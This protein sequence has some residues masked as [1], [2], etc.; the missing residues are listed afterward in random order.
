MADGRIITPF[1][2][3]F[4]RGKAEQLPANIAQ[5]AVDVDLRRGCLEAW[6]TAM[7]V[8]EFGDT[9]PCRVHLSGTCCWTG[10]MNPCAKLVNAA[11]C[12]MTIRSAPCEYPTHA[13]DLCCNPKWCRLGL[14]KPDAPEIEAE[15]TLNV[16]EFTYGRRYVVTFC[17][18][19]HEGPPSP[20]SDSY[21]LNK[22]DPA[23]VTFPAIPKE[24]CITHINLYRLMP[25]GEVSE[26]NFL[27]PEDLINSNAL[28]LNQDTQACYFKV[29]EIPVI[30]CNPAMPFIIDTGS[31]IC[32]DRSL[33]L[34]DDNQPPKEGDCIV[35]ETRA[36]NYVSYNGR[37]VSFSVRHDPHSWPGKARHTMDE[38]VEHVCICE[39]TVFVFT[40][41]TVYTIQDTAKCEDATCRE[42]SRSKCPVPLC[43][44]E[45]CI[46]TES[47]VVFASRNGWIRIAPDGSYDNISKPFFDQRS[48]DMLDPGSICAAKWDGQIVFTSSQGTWL[49]D[50][51]I[52]ASASTEQNLTQL[53]T[54]PVQWVEGKGGELYF[55]DGCDVKEFNAG[56]EWMPYTWKSAP[57]SECDPETFNIFRVLFDDL[58]RQ[59]A[60]GQDVHITF[61]DADGVLDSLKVSEQCDH[62]ICATR[63]EGVCVELSGR[64]TVRTLKYAAG[65]KC[66]DRLS[67]QLG[68]AA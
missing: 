13:T 48:W 7:T 65:K 63:A 14:P 62:R 17:N 23:I 20:P 16:D 67:E 29:A 28:W 10:E 6:R 36:G 2:G 41:S 40:C 21:K 68:A 19:C 66:L 47:G 45:S 12:E 34:T 35:G 56:N 54:Q 51:A 30:N 37:N 39:N 27:H 33:L 60:L 38:D 15:D 31:M 1:R 64:A 18:E 11:L 50:M 58:P 26:A 61:S 49:M 44:K 55:Y 43:S 32:K 5:T 46:V 52:G 22:E 8:C 9:K 59:K 42:L 3:L 24:W 53:S 25:V 57:Q 4:P